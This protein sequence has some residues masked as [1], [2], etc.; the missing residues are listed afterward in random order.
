VAARAVAQ[1]PPPAAAHQP[2]PPTAPL[3]AAAAPD[4]A[5]PAEI[6]SAAPALPGAINVQ[7]ASVRTPD[8]ARAEWARLKHDNADLLGHLRAFAERADLGEQ[9]VY[10]R[11]EAG[12]F[13]DAAAAARLCGELKRRDFGCLVAR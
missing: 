10:Y 11:V 1:P 2:A 9:G 12:P 7:L 3:A 5:A 4:A 6:K 13:S 8:E